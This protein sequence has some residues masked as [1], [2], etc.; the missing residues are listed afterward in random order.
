MILHVLSKCP[1]LESHPS[2][3][4]TTNAQSVAML[5]RPVWNPEE[6]NPPPALP[7]PLPPPPNSNS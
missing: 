4:V 5:P 7:S 6:A 1:T 3:L 2:F